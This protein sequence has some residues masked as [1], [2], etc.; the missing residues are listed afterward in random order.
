V[1]V[2][3]GTDGVGRWSASKGRSQEEKAMAQ[4]VIVGVLCIGVT[5]FETR[6]GER[7]LVCVFV[8]RGSDVGGLICEETNRQGLLH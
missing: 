5:F 3:E 1:K 7:I 4:N 2:V 8:R 6:G